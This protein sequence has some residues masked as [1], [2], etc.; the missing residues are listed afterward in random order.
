MKKTLSLL[1]LVVGQMV[2]AQ[3]EKIT[4]PSATSRRYHEYRQAISE[5]AHHLA[6]IKTISKKI[7]ADKEGNTRLA[8]KDY[9]ALTFEEKFT[10]NMIHGEDSSQNCDAMMGIMS[11]ERKIFKYIPDAFGDEITWSVRQREFLKSNRD[12]VIPLIRATM[13]LRQ[14]VG[15]NLKD[16]IME[17]NGIELIPDLIATYKLKRKDHDVLTLLMLLM[18]EGDFSEFKASASYTKLFGENAN[19]KSFLDASPANQ[20][21]IMERAMTYYKSKTK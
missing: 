20:K 5:P 21:L 1:L 4:H 8:D 16:A 11:E 6:K 9:E 19:Y 18:K 13:N 2:L 3:D 12:K 10:F 14:R 7:K 15:A 17:V